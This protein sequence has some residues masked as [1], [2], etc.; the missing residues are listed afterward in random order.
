MVKATE[1]KKLPLT[2]LADRH[3]GLTPA[4]AAAYIEAAEVSLERHNQSPTTFELIDDDQATTIEV[5]WK[6]PSPQIVHRCA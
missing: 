1:P 6:S 3:L 4:I 2:A 5:I